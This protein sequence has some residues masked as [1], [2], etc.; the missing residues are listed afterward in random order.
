MGRARRLRDVEGTGAEA[1]PRLRAVGPGTDQATDLAFRAMERDRRHVRGA[2]VCE[3]G[4]GSA[5]LAVLAARWRAKRVLAVDCDPRALKEAR[6]LARA[7]GCAIEFREGDLL[8]GV[9]ERFDI[10]VA[11][12]PQKPVPP[13]FKLPLGQ[14][15]GPR[16]DAILRRFL[17]QAAR[18]LNPGGRLYLFLHTL[19]SPG[20]RVL[21]GRYFKA[22]VVCWRR[23]HVAPG[24]YP[25]TLMAHWLGLTA[26]GEAVIHPRPGRRGGHT[27]YAMQLVAI[28]KGSGT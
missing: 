17:P 13:G 22:R 28:R 9:T 26:R 15:G 16:G 5:V 19:S 7:H 1:F 2:S 18:R 23:R 10:L 14:D 20:I 12:L 21:L 4:C 24:E 8:T 25:E 11:N 3:V 6:R 27:F